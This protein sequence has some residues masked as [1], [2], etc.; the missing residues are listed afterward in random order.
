M[1]RLLKSI[2]ENRVGEGDSPILL[3]GL[4]KI[5]T[6]PDDS[7]SAAESGTVPFCFADCAKSGQS[8]AVFGSAR[9]VSVFMP[10]VVRAWP[11][12]NKRR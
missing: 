5:G 1:R 9:G 4:R 6:V 11:T 8:P 2:C 3:R 7:E 10:L 12:K